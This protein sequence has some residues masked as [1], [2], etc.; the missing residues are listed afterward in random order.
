MGDE[1]LGLLA[2]EDPAELVPELGALRIIK[3][4]RICSM[5]ASA[6]SW[7]QPELLPPPG[8]SCA[9]SKISPQC[10]AWSTL[11]VTVTIHS[12]RNALQTADRIL[13][14][15]GAGM[16]VD[17]GLPDFRGS[18]GFWREYPPYRRLGFSFEQ[19]ANPARFA[20]DPRLGWGFYGHRLQLYR[21]TVPHDG[22]EMLREVIGDR[23][24]FVFTSNVDGQ[25][26]LA[27]YETDPIYEVHGSIH[28]LQCSEPCSR[29]I[30]SAFDLEIEI[31]PETMRAVSVLP[32]CPRCDSVARPNILMFGDW[33]FI[34]D[35]CGEQD[36][37]YRDWHASHDGELVV[38]EMGA[39]TALPTIRMESERQQRGGA[40]LI[41]IN[42]R[43]S[44]GPAGTLGLAT[45]ALDALRAIT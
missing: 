22:F 6:R 18:S 9:D 1:E 28:H 3:V 13:V 34:G 40:T 41:R 42:P 23:P 20:D 39:G 2:L 31:D 12:A 8:T 38:V 10:S 4:S 45:G 16:G 36:R 14:C 5:S 43:E 25:F 37:A 29:D 30:W 19:M 17:S 24:S 7:C 21:D 26:Q 32:R 44:H 35:R 27:G 15:A 11:T 33:S